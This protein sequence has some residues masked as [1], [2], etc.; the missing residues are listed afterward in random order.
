M[1]NIRK[2]PHHHH[3]S[4]SRNDI[5]RYPCCI[6]MLLVLFNKIRMHSYHTVLCLFLVSS[7]VPLIVNNDPVNDRCVGV[8]PP[9]SRSGFTANDRR[10]GSSHSCQ[11][12][13]VRVG[14]SSSRRG[15]ELSLPPFAK[16]RSTTDGGAHLPRRLCACALN[17]KR[18]SIVHLGAG[19]VWSE[20][21]Y[22]YFCRFVR[23]I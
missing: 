11:R 8:S 14:V 20:E 6:I 21:H 9:G 19:F 13:G 2:S 7:L 1:V 5:T 15:L 18:K 17:R 3:I 16:G 10:L 12:V 4:R 23:H 22:N